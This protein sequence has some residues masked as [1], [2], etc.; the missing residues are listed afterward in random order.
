M[1]V[2]GGYTEELEQSQSFFDPGDCA[3]NPLV[4]CKLHI[5][6]KSRYQTQLLDA[7]TPS[8]P[9]SAPRSIISLLD[10][11]CLTIKNQQ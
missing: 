4:E 2:P 7:P 5:A 8:Q 11:M 3:C 1:M 6:A 10:L 9:G